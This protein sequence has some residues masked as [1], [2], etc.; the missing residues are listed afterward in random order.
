VFAVSLGER[1]RTLL[2]VSGVVYCAHMLASCSAHFAVRYAVKSAR[3]DAGLSGPFDIDVPATPCAVSTACG[4][5]VAML[6]L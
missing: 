2:P 5:A 3:A 1:T 4:T 6:T